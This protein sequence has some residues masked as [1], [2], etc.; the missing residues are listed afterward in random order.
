MRDNSFEFGA[1]FADIC[2]PSLRSR[3]DI[4]MT[5]NC[6]N[7]KLNGNAESIE[8]RLAHRTWLAAD[9]KF[10]GQPQ[11]LNSCAQQ[12]D[13]VQQG[14]ERF[15]PS[16]RIVGRRRKRGDALQHLW[17]EREEASYFALRREKAEKELGEIVLFTRRGENDAEETVEGFGKKATIIRKA[18]VSE[19]RDSVGFVKDGG[20]ACV[21]AIAKFRRRIQR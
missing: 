13:G 20:D 16:S 9:A 11:T 8:G 18:R 5:A 21:I 1:T 6:V 12:A 15:L 3:G 19:E 2:F 17:R 10:F 14:F 4:S 7:Q